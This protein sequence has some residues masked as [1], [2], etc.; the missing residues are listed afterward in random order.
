MKLRIN[1]IIVF[2]ILIINSFLVL[3]FNYFNGD[4]TFFKEIRNNS[5]NNIEL[6]SESFDSKTGYAIIIGISDYPGSS[7]DLSFC[8]DD[9]LGVYHMLIDDYNFELSNIIYLSDSKATKE[10][11][12][13]AFDNISTR[14]DSNDLFIFL[15]SHI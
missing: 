6:I 15:F 4:T 8:D 7:Y 12:N 9:A 2:M 14:I 11:I 5:D 1:S 10:A 13:L 3:R